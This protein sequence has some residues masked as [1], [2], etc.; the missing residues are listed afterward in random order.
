MIAC[1][2]VYNFIRKKKLEDELFDRCD[3][4]S[5][6]DSDGEGD[7]EDLEGPMNDTHWGSQATQYMNDLRD[8]IA[9]KL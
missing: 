8:Q 1:I 2:A 5:L 4:T 7:E 9:L 3:Q 6:S